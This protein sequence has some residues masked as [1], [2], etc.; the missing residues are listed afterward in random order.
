MGNCG[1]ASLVK[2]SNRVT[3]GTESCLYNAFNFEM[4][5]PAT[6][7]KFTVF[8]VPNKVKLALKIPVQKL[9]AKN[10]LTSLFLYFSLKY[11][12]LLKFNS[13]QLKDYF[14]P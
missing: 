8:N 12:K 11:L 5:K 9:E 14:N 3:I 2:Q 6:V 4:I 10:W 7:D 1:L 13:S